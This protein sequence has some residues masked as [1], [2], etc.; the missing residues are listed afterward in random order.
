M[1]SDVSVELWNL[2]LDLP[3]SLLFTESSSRSEEG[4]CDQQMS[5]IFRTKHSQRYPHNEYVEIS[6]E[7][8]MTPNFQRLNKVCSS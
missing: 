2:S 4:G 1:F 3:T 6:T 8:L 5:P 7:S